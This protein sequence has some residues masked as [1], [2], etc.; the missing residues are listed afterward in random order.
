[1]ILVRTGVIEIGL[2]SECDFTEETF[3]AGPIKTLL[4]CL[5]MTEVAIDK[6][7]SLAN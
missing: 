2:K 3:G 6:F 5:G 4:H 7:N 1:M